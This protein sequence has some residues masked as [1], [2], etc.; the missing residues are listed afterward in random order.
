MGE[1]EARG[2]VARLR[3][4]LESITV[5]DSYADLRRTPVAFP[6]PLLITPTW[7]KSFTSQLAD[8]WKKAV[9]ALRAATRVII[10]GY[11]MPPTDQH[12]R[13]LLAAGLQDNISLQNI[14]FVNL[15]L[16]EENTKTQLEGRLHSLFRREHF[17]RGIIQLVAKNTREFFTGSEPSGG[18]YRTA[19]G[20]PLNSPEL[21]PEQ[22]RWILHEDGSKS[23]H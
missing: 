6:S 4:M 19:I 10:L 3:R 5:Y 16:R 17:D 13:Y 15:G 14:F 1:A 2:E 21:A 12:F 7:N 9:L 8:I 22:A 20:R 11:S 18:S 23:I